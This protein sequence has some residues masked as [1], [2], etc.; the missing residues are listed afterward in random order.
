MSAYI[1]KVLLKDTL[2]K[3]E[4]EDIKEDYILMSEVDI[5]KL[6]APLYEEDEDIC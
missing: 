2:P 6:L 3:D 1:F 5:E 4:W